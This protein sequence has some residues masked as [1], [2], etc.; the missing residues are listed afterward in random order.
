LGEARL[1][2]GPSTAIAKFP[3]TKCVNLR[4]MHYVNPVAA[5]R[6]LEASLA[7]CEAASR[8]LTSTRAQID[9]FPEGPG[10]RQ[11]LES[12]EFARRKAAEA[13][14]KAREALSCERAKL[15]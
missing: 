9:S 13:E 7:Q 11:A 4:R 12:F 1:A 2:A 8:S 14:Q 15:T 5:I 10:K 3:V 6:E